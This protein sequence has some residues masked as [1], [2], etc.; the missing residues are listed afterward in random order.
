VPVG[1]GQTRSV[2]DTFRG[3]TAEARWISLAS[4]SN[5]GIL[6]KGIDAKSES[7]A[8]V[9][10]LSEC[11][12]KGGTTCHL[13]GAV[14]NKCIAMAVGDKTL[15]TSDGSTQRQAEAA[16]V[17]KCAN[18]PDTHCS[19]YFSACAEPALVN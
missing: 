2:E 16:A 19:T 7:E 8:N 12:Q 6:G 13:I 18:G 9:A 15:A 4:D 1:S 14:K 5:K 17:E 3:P 10:A 11:E